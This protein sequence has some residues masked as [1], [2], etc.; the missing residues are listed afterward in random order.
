MRADIII[1]VDS[2]DQCYHQCTRVDNRFPSFSHLI[3]GHQGGV[4]ISID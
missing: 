4:L 2:T 1:T 3:N